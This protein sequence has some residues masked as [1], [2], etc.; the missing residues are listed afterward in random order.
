MIIKKGTSRFVLL[1]GNYTF[2]FPNL[3][4]GW[5]MT[6][7]GFIHNMN[8]KVL[9]DCHFDGLCP[10]IYSNGWG[11]VNIM[12]RCQTLSEEELERYV[13]KKHPLIEGDL[14]E[15]KPDSFGWLKGEIVVVDYG[16]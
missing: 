2:K 11:L 14:V 16:D 15:Y 4:Y 13:T 3:F 10:L 5:K 7:Y 6:L 12:P 1:I 8:E 9:Y